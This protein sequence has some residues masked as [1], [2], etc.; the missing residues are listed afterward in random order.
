MIMA[1][2]LNI[3]WADRR[4]ELL[5]QR[6]VVQHDTRTVIVTDLH[7][8]KADHFRLSGVPVPDACN[9][10]TLDRLARVCESSAAESLIILGDFFHSRAG[11]TD[12]LLRRLRGWRDR[13][14]YLDIYNVRGNHDV[15][16]GDPPEYLGIEVWDTPVRDG[17]V[18]YAHEPVER[19]DAA[20]MAGH[21][22]PAVR[23]GGASGRGDRMRLPAFVFGPRCALLPAFGAFTGMKCVQPKANDRVYV[24][25]PDRVADVS[26][27]VAPASA[28]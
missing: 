28:V 20:V 11:V 7:L 4:W 13:V 10:D 21:V 14:S 24:V 15:G 12:S 3:D 2:T 8:G 5:P 27:A 25:G 17:D 16:A 1:N 18:V 19:E 6:V 23:L 22:H 26:S 9:G